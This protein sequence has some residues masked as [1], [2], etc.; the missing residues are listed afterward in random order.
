MILQPALTDGS[1]TSI[2][3]GWQGGR[4]I[5]KASGTWGSGTLTLNWCDTA[6]GTFVPIGTGVTLTADG[7]TGFEVAI[8]F[9]KASLSGNTGANVIFGVA[10]TN[11]QYGANRQ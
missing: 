8:G 6:A 2:A 11:P 1:P 5:L 9:V 7:S 10:S 3:I 4:G